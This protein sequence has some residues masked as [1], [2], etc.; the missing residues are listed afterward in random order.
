M[1]TIPD[2]AG[3]TQLNHTYRRRA[4]IAQCLIALEQ[5]NCSGF[6]AKWQA[7]AGN[8]RV[9]FGRSKKSTD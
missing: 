2:S 3:F 8:R 5:K 1:G 4:K 9:K 6:L 7:V